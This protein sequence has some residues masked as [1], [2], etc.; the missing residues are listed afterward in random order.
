MGLSNNIPIQ[1]KG[2]LNLPDGTQKFYNTSMEFNQL[3]NEEYCIGFNLNSLT[4]GGP[5][6]FSVEI[7]GFTVR[8]IFNVYTN[9]LIISNWEPNESIR[10]ITYSH[11]VPLSP[12]G[13]F[14]S[15]TYLTA[16]ENG[17]L[18][19][20]LVDTNSTSMWENNLIALLM[21]GE[22]GKISELFTEYDYSNIE[23]NANYPADN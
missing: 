15:E 17:E 11:E 10:I 20:E 22:S 16:D 21:Y 6:E 2:I 14:H 19:L 1:L 13:N 12:T 18:W 9:T 8:D 23:E 4:P 5:Y 7:P 3:G